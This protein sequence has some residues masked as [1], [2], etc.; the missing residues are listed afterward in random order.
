MRACRAGGPISQITALRIFLQEMGAA[1]DEERDLPPYDGKRDFDEVRAFFDDRCC[2]CGSELQAGRVAQDHLVA[3]NK[4]SLGLHA[5]GNV[6]PACQDCNAK[7]QG[8]EWHAYLVKRA[9]A[10]ASERY[11]RVTE[12]V[13]Y[14]RYAPDF[15]DLAYVASE[16]YDE[17]GAIS[18]TLIASK[19]K[20]A[21]E[22]L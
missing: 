9:G 15:K 4:T 20:R 12:F 21:R 2:Y 13:R 22:R 5:W 19:V 10:N 16:L 14:Y 3:M 7:K 8:S 18:M 6:V 1:Y 17:V 11:E